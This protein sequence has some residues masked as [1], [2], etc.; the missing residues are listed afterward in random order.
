V[1]GTTVGDG[2]FEAGELFELG[3]GLPNNVVNLLI[4]FKNNNKLGN[5]PQTGVVFGSGGVIYGT[6]SGTYDGGTDSTVFPAQPRRQQTR[7][8]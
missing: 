6:T 8:A 2:K 3:A 5:G 4:S 7:A 1:Y